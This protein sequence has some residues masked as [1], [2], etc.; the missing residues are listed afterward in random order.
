[1]ESLLTELNY[2]I[3][4]GP[5]ALPDAVLFFIVI[6]LYRYKEKLSVLFSFLV[7]ALLFNLNPLYVCLIVASW[8]LLNIDIKI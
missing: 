4:V 7:L 2:N 3:F 8:K 6:V 5:F 1:M